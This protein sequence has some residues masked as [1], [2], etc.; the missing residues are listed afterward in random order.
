M[1]HLLTYINVLDFDSILNPISS[2][3]FIKFY[4][5]DTAY[6]KLSFDIHTDV[7]K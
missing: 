6:Y 5:N 2:I 4:A 3:M 1:Q 7:P